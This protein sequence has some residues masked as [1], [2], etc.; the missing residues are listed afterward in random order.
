[1]RKL[2]LVLTLAV[3][4]TT[5]SMAV[6]TIGSKQYAADTLFRRQ[7]GP[8]IV[9]TIIRIPDYPLNVYLL[10]AD[11]NN[12]YNRVETTQG[13]NLLGKT[14][15]L[16]TAAKRQTTASKRVLAGCNANFWCV[17]NQGAQSN[18]ML[19]SP[20]GGVVRNDTVI[21]NTNNVNDT[22]DGGPSRTAIAAID[23]DKN[24]I[25]GHFTWAATVGSDRLNAPLAINK[26]NKRNLAN[27]LCLWNEYFGRTREFETN[28]TA[29]NTTGTNNADNYY[30]E[31][32]EGSSWAVNKPMTFVIKK[33]V[34]DADRQTLGSFDA[35]IT[36]TGS[37]KTA[38]RVHQEGD[39]IVVNQGWTTNEPDKQK[40]SPWIENL[41]EGNAPV[42]HN[43]ELTGR[44]YDETYNSQ[45]YSRTAYGCSF[46]GKKLYMIVIDK[47]QSPKYG[48]SS[49]C[50]TEVMCQILKSLF[51]DI[52]EVVNYDAGGS[53]EM[54]VNGAIINKT[55]EGTP[56]AVATGWLLES[57]A[58]ADNEVASIQFADAA[59]R[60]PIYSS[61][62]PQIIAYNKYGDVINEDLQG[63]TL[64]CDA[65][66]GTAEGQDLTVAGNVLTGTLTANYNGITASLNI[67]TMYAQPAISLKPVITVDDQA[68]PLEVTATVNA[69]T[70]YYEAENL[71]WTV[72]DPTIAVVE[73]GKIRGLKNGNTLITCKIGEFLDT[74]S[75]SVEISPEAYLHQSWD[76]WTLK[77][78]GASN[79]SVSENGLV[80]YTYSS[81]RAPYIKL[82]KDVTFYSLP[83]EIGLTFVSSVPLDYIQIDVRNLNITSANYQKFEGNNGFEAGKEYTIKV[84]MDQIGG[85]NSLNTYP[86]NIQEIRFVPN[87]TTATAGAQTIDIKAF[88]A[89][90]RKNAVITGDVNGDGE[91]NVSDVTALINKILGTADYSDAVCDINADGTINVSDVT[92]LINIILAQ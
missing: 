57:I 3:I 18:Y 24:L 64:S 87:K 41:V 71:E 26:I 34:S 49:G 61:Y 62:H 17:A 20:L 65:S 76:G 80:N 55:T 75:V 37:M 70:Y 31:L 88:Y 45:V 1:M 63:F 79:L 15:A 11:M 43:G 44:N 14:E 46:D 73:N 5:S 23:H 27:E 25:F 6:I 35:C 89:H 10:E 85:I 19:G 58:P 56:R 66:L 69:Q 86:I 22:W 50:S 53:A 28:W 92:A 40:I 36:A 84:D 9:N 67:T 29:N 52:S 38:M 54:L 83:D 7:I 42:M 72:E 8:G 16:V 47:S 39:V 90:Y 60:L 51:P 59:L 30:L 68:W 77:G 2:L 82:L 32:A 12:P 13:Q 91:V 48:L 78:S 33:I 74:D 21:V 4:C 81:T